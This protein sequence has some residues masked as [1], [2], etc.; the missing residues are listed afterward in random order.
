MSNITARYVD[1][2]LSD[3][4]QD[5]YS[6]PGQTLLLT[7]LGLDLATTVESLMESMDGDCGLPESISDVEIARAVRDAIEGVD[8]RYI[9]ENGNRCDEPEEDR[10]GDEPYLYVVLE[11]DATVVKMRLTVDVEYLA[12]GE[13]AYDL[14]QILESLVRSAAG[15]GA[16]VGDTDA[17]VASWGATAEEIH[18]GHAARWHSVAEG[19]ECSK[20]GEIRREPYKEP[21]G[22]R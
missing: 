11:W 10:D 21:H 7:S 17:E 1:T 13:S 15:N 5:S 22:C 2:C 18:D 14:K 20:C 16:L 12:N 19:W 3:Y 8:L 4:L 6:R 9:D